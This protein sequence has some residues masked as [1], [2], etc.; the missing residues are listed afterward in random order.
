MSCLI[1]MLMKTLN[2]SSFINQTIFVIPLYHNTMLID[3]KTFKTACRSLLPLLPLRAP[4][5]LWY[6]S[7]HGMVI[8]FVR[9]LCRWFYYLR[10]TLSSFYA[11]SIHFSTFVCSSCKCHY[12]YY[13]TQ[14]YSASFFKVFRACYTPVSKLF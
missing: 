6:C 4:L 13:I 10:W 7:I 11:D 2:C 12:L 5:F 9:D 3:L 1:A 8:V 14:L